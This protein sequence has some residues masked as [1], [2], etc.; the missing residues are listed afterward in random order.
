MI[1]AISYLHL[2]S[3]TYCEN[4]YVKAQHQNKKRIKSNEQVFVIQP[5]QIIFVVLGLFMNRGK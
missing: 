2:N 3:H 4:E 1:F 5:A